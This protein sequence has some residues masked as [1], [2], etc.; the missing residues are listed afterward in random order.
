MNDT[1]TIICLF[2]SS[3]LLITFGFLSTFLTKK[4]NDF[5]EN[6]FKVFIK[7]KKMNL[8]LPEI[9]VKKEIELL[10]ILGGIMFIFGLVFVFIFSTYTAFVSN[11]F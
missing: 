9:K 2:L 3:T 1:G 5:I 10:K 4:F 8:Y 7:E 6:K 11:V